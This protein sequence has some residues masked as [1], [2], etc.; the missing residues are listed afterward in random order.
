MEFCVFELDRVVEGELVFEELAFFLFSGLGGA[1]DFGLGLFPGND[2]A[3]PRVWEFVAGAA[4]DGVVDFDFDGFE[5]YGFGDV[6]DKMFDIELVLLVLLL[7]FF[8]SL[9]GSPVLT[10]KL[11]TFVAVVAEECFF[12][13]PDDFPDFDQLE[14]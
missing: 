3:F 13:G 2:H 9:G 10:L 6:G 5:S 14:F 11:A 8:F 4:A 12:V 7:D 1:P